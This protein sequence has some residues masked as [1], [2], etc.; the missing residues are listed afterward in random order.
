MK[1][2][3]ELTVEKTEKGE[4]TTRI[5]YNSKGDKGHASISLLDDDLMKSIEIALQPIL[6]MAPNL[7]QEEIDDHYERY[8][9]NDNK[10]FTL[11]EL[12][13]YV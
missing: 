8:K 10:I 11:K 1:L 9:H 3:M 12:K 2:E 7:T 6:V 5:A 4:Y 13:Q